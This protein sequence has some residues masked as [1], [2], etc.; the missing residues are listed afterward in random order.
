MQQLFSKLQIAR[1]FVT[2]LRDISDTESIFKLIETLN[3]QEDLQA[4]FPET[5]AM[6]AYLDASFLQGFPALEDLRAMPEGSLG[7]ALAVHMD[8]LGVDFSQ[9]DRKPAPQDRIEQ[10][11]RHVE[12]THDIWHVLTGFDTGPA[13]EFGLQAFGLAQI[14]AVGPLMLVILGLARCL[15]T[16]SQEIAPIMDAL[17]EGWRMGRATEPLYGTD[18]RPYLVRPLDEVRAHFGIEPIEPNRLAEIPE[19]IAA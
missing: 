16:G 10:I 1:H 17:T 2:I 14:K 15:K 8:T 18:F 19:Q 9:F 13:S 3:R 4:R 7:R 6:S 5:P 11:E 12:E